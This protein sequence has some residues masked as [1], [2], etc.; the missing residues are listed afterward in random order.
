MNGR[1]P[2]AGSRWYRA[3]VSLAA[4]WVA[5]NC[6][7]V[8][9]GAGAGRTYRIEAAV[10]LFAAAALPGLARRP[11]ASDDALPHTAGA[12]LLCAVPALLWLAL[13]APLLGYPFLSDDYVFLELYDRYGQVWRAPEFFRPG[14]AAVY[15]SL[16]RIGHATPWPFHALSFSLHFTSACLVYSLVRLFSGMQPAALIAFTVFLLNPLQLEAVLWASGLQELLWTTAVLA[17][18]R[19]YLATRVLTWGRIGMTLALVGAA[20]A[21]KETAVSYVLLLPLADLALYRLRRGP[22]LPWGYAAFVGLFAAFIALRSSL[23]PVNDEFLAWPTRFFLKQF[24]ATPYKVFVQPWSTAAWDPPALVWFAAA[25]LPVLLVTGAILRRQGDARLLAGPLVILLSTA[26][27]YT[28]FYVAPDLAGARY[29]YFAC[30]GWAMF[31]GCLVALACRP[32]WALRVWIVGLSAV[33]AGVLHVNLDPWRTAGA[34]VTS[35]HEAARSGHDPLRIGVLAPERRLP[36]LEVRDGVPDSYWGVGLFRNGY[37]EFLRWS[38][39]YGRAGQDNRPPRLPG[40]AAASRD[41]LR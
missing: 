29:V 36:G 4:L 1:E 41:T 7:Y 27:V 16:E 33:L 21:S 35:M 10:F 3:L 11:A 24:V 37:P 26:P 14:F 40:S 32:A 22:L 31:L 39:R 25:V 28:Y 13:M 38:A 19:C 8:Y 23:V 18:L 17:A 30:A 5:G 34:I 9:A 2:L 6:A 20:L 15:L 12:A